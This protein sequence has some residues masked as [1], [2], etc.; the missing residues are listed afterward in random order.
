MSPEQVVGDPLVLDTPS[1]VY[2]L[3]VILYELLVGK[4]PYD[5]NRK[6]LPQALEVIRAAEPASLSS[7]NRSYRGDIDTI[8]AKALE[9]DKGRRYG[10]AAELGVISGGIWQTSQ[11]RRGRRAP[12]TRYRSLRGG[13]KAWWPGWPRFLWYWRWVW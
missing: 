12:V 10:S 8:V 9:K 5:V 6:A 11:L 7:I 1:D 13:T 4:L 3:G 2:A